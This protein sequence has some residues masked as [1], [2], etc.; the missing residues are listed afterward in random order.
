MNI[1]KRPCT[2]SF[3]ILLPYGML[4]R[5]NKKP[6]QM[7]RVCSFF[8]FPFPLELT[9]IRMAD[10]V[11]ALAEHNRVKFETLKSVVNKYLDKCG[12]Q[13]VAMDSLFGKLGYAV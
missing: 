10:R 2:I 7:I 11:L 3:C 5:R 1:Q 9:N 4:K 8:A 12:R 6:Q 13:W